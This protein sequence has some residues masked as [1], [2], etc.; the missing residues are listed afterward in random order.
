[1]INELRCIAPCNP[2]SQQTT[3]KADFPYGLQKNPHCTKLSTKTVPLS[4]SLSLSISQFLDGFRVKKLPTKISTPLRFH[5]TLSASRSPDSS[6]WWLSYFSGPGKDI[7]PILLVQIGGYM[8]PA[9]YDFLLC[10]AVC[11]GKLSE[12]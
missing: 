2:H 3:N 8:I 7:A 5:P 10:S 9:G 4:L 6:L 12:K 1:M 11:V